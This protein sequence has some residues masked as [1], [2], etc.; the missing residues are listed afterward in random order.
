MDIQN[1]IS[2]NNDYDLQLNPYSKKSIFL[3]AGEKTDNYKERD[4]EAVYAKRGDSKYDK[5]MDTNN[6]D[7]VSYQEYIEYCNKNAHQQDK[8]SNT[9]F[10]TNEDGMFKTTSLSKAINSYA[11]NESEG[12]KGLVNM[13]A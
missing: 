10:K 2:F 5:A 3:N 12:A 1:N 6:D 7:K 11:Q 9:T 13:E 8:K 4:S